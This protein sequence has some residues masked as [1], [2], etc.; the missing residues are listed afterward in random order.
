M[1]KAP[2]I[3]AYVYEVK[4][5]YYKDVLEAYIRGDNVPLDYFVS[6]F[7]EWD[8]DDFRKL[9]SYAVNFN[10]T[11]DDSLLKT[12]FKNCTDPKIKSLYSFFK[13]KPSLVLI[14]QEGTKNSP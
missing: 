2:S 5:E 10:K 12:F 11:G 1:K 6:P 4:E 14:K 9:L 7:K 13:F 3:F 8:K